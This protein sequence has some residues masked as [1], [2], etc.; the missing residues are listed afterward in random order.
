MRDV[1]DHQREH[2]FNRA[3]DIGLA[4]FAVLL[5]RQWKVMLFT[6]VI[7]IGITV[8]FMFA[9]ST[10]Y[11]F[12]TMYGVA[13]F[14][15]AEGLKRGVE[16][17][18]EVIAKIENIFLEQ[19]RRS[20]LSDLDTASLPFEMNISNPDNTLLI[21]ITSIA[22]DKNQ[23]L[24]ERFHEGLVAALKEDQSNLVE[25]LR[26]SLEQQHEA[27]SQAL[28]VAQESTSEGASEL[29]AN[30]LERVFMLERRLESIS[31]GDSSQVAVR[32]LEPVGIS[33]NFILALGLVLAFIFAPLVAMFSI[34]AKKVVIIFREDK[35]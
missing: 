16:T 19:E 32:S 31:E 34:F 11:D 15:T 5:L 27:Y 2:A 3:E 28:S 25:T 7:I 21:R 30:Y 24:I 23:P 29:I 22:S 6:V 9:K 4:E 10:K 8:A 20:I 35:V 1:N 26:S 14:E 33:N 17:P 13:S 12:S 18:E